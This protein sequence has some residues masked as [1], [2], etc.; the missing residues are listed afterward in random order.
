MPRI[1]LALAVL[2]AALVASPALAQPPD[3]QR[4]VVDRRQFL[5]E[6]QT[7]DDPR[8]VPAPP[9]PRGPD[10]TRVLYGGFIFDGTGAEPRIGTIVI[11]RNRISAI[12]GE[13]ERGWPA[14]RHGARRLRP[15]RAAGAD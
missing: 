12:L 1:V 10:G 2:S 5:N 9:V 8:R 11:E 6:V 15:H 13:G 4:Q 3:T 14:G 7:S